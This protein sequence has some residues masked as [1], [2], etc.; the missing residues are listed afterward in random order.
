MYS[1]PTGKNHDKYQHVVAYSDEI[2]NKHPYLNV[3]NEALTSNKYL[4]NM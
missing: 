2:I 3:N 4:H 1:K